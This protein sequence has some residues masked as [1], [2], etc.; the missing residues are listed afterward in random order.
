M[1]VV[2]TSLSDNLYLESRKK[3]NNSAL[4][5]G[6]TQVQSRSFEEL[7]KS[8]FYLDNKEILDKPKGLG[9]WLWKPYI[10][11]KA[12]E[13][14]EH[15][16]IVIYSDCGIEIIKSIIPLIDICKDQDPVLLFGNGN[17]TN[18][19]WTKRD[20][21]VL[22]N[23]DAESYWYSPHCDAAFSIFR[24]CD[25]SIQFLNEWLNYGKDMRII[26]DDANEC[27]LQNLPEFIEH[28]WDQS[29]LSLLAQKYQL[30]LYRMPTQFGNHYKTPGLRVKKE[31][32]CVN[33]LD[34]T[35]VDHYSVIPYYNS[36]YAQLLNHH[37]EK[38]GIEAAHRT[39]N[40]LSRKIVTNKPLINFNLAKQLK[41]LN[42]LF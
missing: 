11:L 21:F 26:T 17:F 28:R 22:M 42:K 29:I 33:Q 24:K 8:D 12:L 37:R 18:A 20:C 15:G 40:T 7:K 1:Q 25:L 36:D 3:L 6:A 32:N 19:T 5:F 23:C 27:G 9:Y 14:I 41:K 13:S 30:S 31:I 34:Q 35:P 16:D 4:R 38:S 39:S 2:I 10:I